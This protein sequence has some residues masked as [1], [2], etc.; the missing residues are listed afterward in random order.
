MRVRETP[1]TMPRPN[2]ITTAIPIHTLGTPASDNPHATPIV[3]ST[4]PNR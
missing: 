2:K 1:M 4:K 3:T